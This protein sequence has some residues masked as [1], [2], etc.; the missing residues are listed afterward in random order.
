MM[1]KY[2]IFSVI[3]LLSLSYTYG[4][5]LTSNE[6]KLIRQSAANIEVDSLY[7]NGNW[8]QLLKQ[9]KNKRIVLLGE[10]NHGSKEVYLSRNDL[11]KNLHEKLGFDVILFESGLGELAPMD[12]YRQ[13]LSA[14]YMT[15]GLIGGWRTLEF[16]NL[17]EYIK[18][19]DISIS[20]FDV[21]RSGGAFERFF[22]IV[23]KSK[24]IDTGLSRNLE[25]RFNNIKKRLS[26]NT[27]PFDSIQHSTLSLIEDYSRLQNLLVSEL[28][29]EFD[30]KLVLAKKTITNRITFLKYQLDFKNDKNWSKRWKARD[31]AMAENIEWLIESLYPN[32]K[33]IIIGHNF[34]IAKYNENEEVM[35]EFLKRS[36]NADMYSIGVF[37]KAG[38]YFDNSGREKKMSPP[39]S[40]RL[41]I[42]HVI[43]NLD[44]NLNFLDIHSQ[45]KK[46]FNWL[47]KK[48]I[49]NDTF[50][51]LSNSNEMVLSKHFDGLL[52]LNS[53]ST[54]KKI[55]WD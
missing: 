55:A 13:K 39:D 4:Q 16:E 35:G 32:R 52:L 30:K 1:T 38:N 27:V 43:N 41:D 6:R 34:H 24:S 53:V 22:E 54:P 10:F 25:N 21:Q 12:I 47:F 14:Q 26:S 18:I 36:Y 15:V 42:K 3:I 44:G 28:N 40:K 33:I 50:I 48:L 51:D 19:K 45:S 2:K 8:S 17:M 31:L 37:A 23:L 11:I 49:I 46:G 29:T 5:G 9:I 20:G 7:E